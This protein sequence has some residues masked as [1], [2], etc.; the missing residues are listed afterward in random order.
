MSAT[1]ISKA[2]SFESI[3][4]SRA[5]PQGTADHVGRDMR[6]RQHVLGIIQATY[7]RFGFSPFETPVLENFEVF[8]GRYGEGEENM[9]GVLPNGKYQPDF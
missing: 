9:L 2:T 5:I 1:T 3:D 6:I 4:L 7:E 8:R